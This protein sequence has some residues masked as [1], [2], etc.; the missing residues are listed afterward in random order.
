MDLVVT[1]NKSFVHGDEVGYFFVI[2]SRG[3]L[4]NYLRSNLIVSP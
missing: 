3:A 2:N 1:P 4:L